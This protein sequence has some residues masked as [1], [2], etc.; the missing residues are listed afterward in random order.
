MILEEI[1]SLMRCGLAFETFNGDQCIL[2]HVMM[3]NFNKGFKLYMMDSRIA[4]LS[5]S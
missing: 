5:P 4:K 2:K 1:F 3:L